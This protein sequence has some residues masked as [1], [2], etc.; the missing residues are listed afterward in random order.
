MQDKKQE[1]RDIAENS[2]EAFIRLVH[3]TR[4]LGAVHSDLSQWMTRRDAKSYQLVLLPRDHMKS[5]VAG[6]YVAWRITKNP[7]IRVLYISSTSNLA[8]KQ[9]KLIKDILNSDIYRFYWPDMTNIDEG[10]RE[11][12]TESEISVDHPKRKYENVRDATVYSVGLT[13]AI[14]GL[15]AD[16]LVLD[17]VVVYENAYTEEGR[18]KTAR[19]YS[20]F[21]SVAGTDSKILVVGTRYHPN[22]LYGELFSKR[23]VRHNDKG[24]YLSEDDLYE[25]FERKV[26]NIGDGSG[27]YLWPRQ[28]NRDGRWFGFNQ[29]ILEEKRANY[30]DQTQFRAQYYN[31]PN[32]FD[33]SGISKD[34]FQY[35]D[36][37]FLEFD[38]TV[39]KLN[40]KRLNV[41][42]AIDFAYT[43]KLGSDF[44]A[45]VVVGVDSSFNYYILDIDRFKT[46][47]ISDFYEHLLRLHNKWHF[48][49]L[50]AEVTAAQIAIVNDLKSSYIRPNG[51]SLSVEEFKPSRYMGA[52]EERM[53]AV[54]QPRY[55][56]R[57]VWHYLGGNCQ[58]L[59]DELISE[60][61]PHD[62]VKD[63]LTSCIEA[64]VAP[65][66]Q[67]SQPR[68][69]AAALAHPRF[70]GF[71]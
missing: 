64:C 32:S 60:H 70:G 22:D 9:L 13:T 10:K 6:C 58:V 35:Y 47:L 65:S 30:L 54:L 38:G 44:T 11:K 45:I 18:E 69:N 66:P 12:W 14:T 34:C 8:T 19:Q 68:F 25:V 61:P 50:R 37:H 48:H 26:E 17:D 67:I 20:F 56:N 31:D 33:G 2:F 7:A 5:Y 43:T 24:E 15:H 23:V 1:A 28:Q 39:W 51:L 4:A 55:N 59:E 62:D 41:F 49:K 36:R 57:Q 40:G 16:L 52:K 53:A 27:E 63:A 42:A 46:E 29:Q 3:P 71:G 21:A